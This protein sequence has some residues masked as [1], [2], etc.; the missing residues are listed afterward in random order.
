MK[1]SPAIRLMF[2]A[3]SVAAPA[4]S[5]CDVDN[6]GTATGQ[7]KKDN[8]KP[9]ESGPEGSGSIAPRRLNAGGPGAP[10]TTKENPAD[11]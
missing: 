9:N 1:A 7:D 2:L 8:L 10:G 4:F 3:A 11:K 6:H 5:G